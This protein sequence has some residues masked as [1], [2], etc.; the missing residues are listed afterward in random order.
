MTN[1]DNIPNAKLSGIDRVNQL[2]LGAR[3][4]VFNAIQTRLA[5]AFISLTTVETLLE[6]ER[7]KVSELEQVI[8]KLIQEKRKTE[9]EE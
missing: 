9:G 5:N 3:D 4:A 8:A 2:E 6:I 1:S 7:E